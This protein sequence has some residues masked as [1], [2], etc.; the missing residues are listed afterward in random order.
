MTYDDFYLCDSFIKLESF[1]KSLPYDIEN[2][3]FEMKLDPSC[4][5]LITVMQPQFQSEN[6]LQIAPPD[7]NNEESLQERL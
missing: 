4:T 3:Q 6:L 7:F 2:M 1:N 5:K